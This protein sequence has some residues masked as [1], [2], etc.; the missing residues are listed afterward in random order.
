MS[1]SDWADLM[2]Q[3]IVHEP[4]TGRDQY[5]APTYGTATTYSCR[6]SQRF[7]RVRSISDTG[8]SVL[9]SHQVWVNGTF[10]P[11]YDDRFTFPNGETPMLLTYEIPY[12]ENGAHH[13]KLYFG[14]ATLGSARG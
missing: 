1:I 8:Q 6:I 12:D 13:L 9:S 14:G 2:V 5:G 3:E 4:C 7:T 11:S 10:V